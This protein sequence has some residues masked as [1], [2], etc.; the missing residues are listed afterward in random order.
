[1]IHVN[2][3]PMTEY[4]ARTLFKKYREKLKGDNLVEFDKSRLQ[5]E[6]L[7]GEL[8]KDYGISKS[9]LIFNLNNTIL[10]NEKMT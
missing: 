9:K 10:E 7:I 3:K 6:W 1:M 2:G 8:S 5:T 4:K